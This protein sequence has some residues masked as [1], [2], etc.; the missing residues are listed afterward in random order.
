MVS[1]ILTTLGLLLT[2]FAFSQDTLFNQTLSKVVVED[3]T[4]T[5]D[6]V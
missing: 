4:T 5:L 6:S 2:Q 3:R 1:K